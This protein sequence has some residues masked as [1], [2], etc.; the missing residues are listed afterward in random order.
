MNV[1]FELYFGPIV[2]RYIFII[3]F[4]PQKFEEKNQQLNETNI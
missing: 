1:T 4:N 3:N 2:F